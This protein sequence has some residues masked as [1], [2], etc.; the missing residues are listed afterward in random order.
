[1]VNYKGEKEKEQRR[2]RRRRRR[3]FLDRLEADHV[4]IIDNRELIMN[5]FSLL[6]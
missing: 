6:G 3:F 1:M 2:R 4:R 5:S